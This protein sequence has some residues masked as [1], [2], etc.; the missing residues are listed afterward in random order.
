MLI[1][2]LQIGEKVLLQST[3]CVECPQVH[4]KSTYLNRHVLA[5]TFLH[6]LG[7]EFEVVTL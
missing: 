6:E 2:M 5:L 3:S 1:V 7:A 4:L